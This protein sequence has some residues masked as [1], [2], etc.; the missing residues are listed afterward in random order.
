MYARMDIKHVCIHACHSQVHRKFEFTQITRLDVEKDIPTKAT[1][2]FA[3]G[4][5]PYQVL[6]A[7]T[8]SGTCCSDHIRYFLCTYARIHSHMYISNHGDV[9]YFFARRP[10]Q[11]LL[12]YVRTYT[13]TH[14]HT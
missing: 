5:R 12:V 7:A 4:Q 10:Y 6:V 14:V 8:I 11:V 1:L 9:Y 2:R 3:G 13:F